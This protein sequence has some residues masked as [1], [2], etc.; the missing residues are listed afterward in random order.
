MIPHAL[1]VAIHLWR[2][3]REIPMTLYAELVDL[4]YDV[5]ALESLY[6]H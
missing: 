4:G 3:D 2:Q 5:P 1:A 6:R